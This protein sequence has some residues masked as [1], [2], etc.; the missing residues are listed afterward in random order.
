MKQYKGHPTFYRLLDELKEL[1]DRKN[2]DYSSEL[3]PL[4]NLKMCEKF[5]ICKAEIGL[6]VRLSDKYSRIIELLAKSKE[7]KVKDE[8][9]IDTLKDMAVYSLLCICLLEDKKVGK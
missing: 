4:S 1:H 6:L 3:D 9:V 8:S 2:H 5:G 7:A